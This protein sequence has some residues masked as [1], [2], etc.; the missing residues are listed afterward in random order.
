MSAWAENA[1]GALSRSPIVLTVQWISKSAGLG[2]WLRAVAAGRD[3]RL[4]TAI[5]T[6]RALLKI[7]AKSKDGVQNTFLSHRI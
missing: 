1:P 4:R 6:H 5:P 7:L 3:A 2:G